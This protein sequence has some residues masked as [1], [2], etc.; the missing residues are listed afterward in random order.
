VPV[1]RELSVTYAGLTFGGSTAR[2]IDGYTVVEKDYVTAAFEF[3]FITTATSESAFAT[4]CAAVE[5]AFRTPRG[6]L[7]VTQGSATLLS[8]K[9]SNNTGLNAYPTIQKQGDI[10]DTG[11]S[12]FYNVR[13]D[14]G[15]PADNVNTNFRRFSTVNVEYSIENQR[16]VTI[17]GTYTANSTDGTTGSFATYLANSGA[18]F[19]SV[20]TG[21]S[22]TAVFEPVGVPRIER[23]ETD[24]I[25]NFTALFKEIIFP[26][27]SANT[28]EPGLKDPTLSITVER[29][30]PGDSDFSSISFGQS[31][32]NAGPSGNTTG[33]NRD[34][35]QTMGVTPPP[36]LTVTQERP[37]LVTL[38]YTVGIDANVITGLAGMQAKYVGTIRPFLLLQ[39]SQAAAGGTVVLID[40][41]PD[42]GD[43]YRNLFSVT[44][45]FQAYISDILSKRITISDRTNE[46][47][48][49]RF[50]WTGNP[51]DYYEYQ[52]GI[53]RLKTITEE[54]EEVVN[55][56]D[57]NA[58]IE[59]KVI[60]GP[61]PLGIPNADK[62]TVLEREPRGGSVKRGLVG[63][64]QV[65]IG[66]CI[67]V[68]VMQFRNKYGSSI[69]NAGGISG[70]VAT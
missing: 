30:A 49:L 15:L 27:S 1:S 67:I 64:A 56:G 8:L 7:V 34:V 33:G 63:G 66:Q 44:M 24:K 55:T 2:Q 23:D 20:L 10:G 62:W 9:Q 70:G 31:Q 47:K 21:I 37:R 40:E 65:Y 18:Y 52:S 50:V 51:Y 6:D 46:G 25:T 11:R 13:I 45:T 26:Q 41:A 59:G 54:F 16:T 36:G 61:S 58:Y 22:A 32:G 57:S 69:A 17:S 28:D 29:Q 38:S 48:S 53:V 68:T 60:A 43:M 4:E 12:R 35:T 5:A 39:A 14:F 42:Y 19:T 3:S